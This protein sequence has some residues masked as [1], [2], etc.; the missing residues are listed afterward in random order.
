[1]TTEW[2]KV[3]LSAI[4]LAVPWLISLTVFLTRLSMKVKEM[5]AKIG[6]INTEHD[7]CML[8]REAIEANLNNIMQDMRESMAEI[9]ANLSW[10]VKT[11]KNGKGADQ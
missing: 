1:M 7:S 10:I 6:K 3:L 11:A 8:R 2:V 9:R 5:E 4:A